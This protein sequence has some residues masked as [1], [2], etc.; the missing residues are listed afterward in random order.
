MQHI[1][2]PYNGNKSDLKEYCNTILSVLAFFPRSGFDKSSFLV[3][4]PRLYKKKIIL[5]SYTF[6][7]IVIKYKNNFGTSV[8][9]MRNSTNNYDIWSNFGQNKNPS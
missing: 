6:E 3:L 7:N 4:A 1:N 2:V 5:K 9:P 8:G